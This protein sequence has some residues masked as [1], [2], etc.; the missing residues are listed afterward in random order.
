MIR[1]LVARG[2]L[3]AIHI[4]RSVRIVKASLDAFIERKS[5]GNVR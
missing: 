2:E 1:N 5:Q 3:E 4:E